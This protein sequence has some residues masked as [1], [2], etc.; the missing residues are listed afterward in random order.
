MT[1]NRE[2]FLR[3]PLSI[4]KIPNDGVTTIGVPSSNAGWDVLRYELTSFVCKGEYQRGLERILSSYLANLSEDRQPAV[5]VSG[6]YGSG[7]SH[8]VR[9]LEAMWRDYQFPQGDTARGILHDLP[10]S[11]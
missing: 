3:D 7:K 8:L 1:L 9:V 2:V 5:W 11:I 6:F 4:P 10:E